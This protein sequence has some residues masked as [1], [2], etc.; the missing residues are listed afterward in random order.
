MYK[1]LVLVARPHQRYR[2]A[3]SSKGTS[4]YQDGGGSRPILLRVEPE[5]E[6]FCQPVS[7]KVL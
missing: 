3:I 6:G 4:L 7:S 2:A 1:D 5:T